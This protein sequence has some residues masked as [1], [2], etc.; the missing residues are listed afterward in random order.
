LNCTTECAAMS[1]NTLITLE[2]KFYRS[3]S[4]DQGIKVFVLVSIP[5]TRGL[6][7]GLEFFKKVLTTTLVHTMHHVRGSTP[8]ETPMLTRIGVG[9]GE[10]KL[11][12][13]ARIADRTV[14]QQTI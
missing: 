10:A 14:L 3:W 7:H 13:R 5:R 11:A 6:G 12:L 1:M 4:R 8:K 2:V 9:Y